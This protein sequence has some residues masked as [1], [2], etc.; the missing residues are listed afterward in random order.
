MTPAKLIAW[1]HSL[2]LTQAGAA[3]A[4]GLSLR[5]YARLEGGDSPISRVIELA[6]RQVAA[7]GAKH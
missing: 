4:L 5:Q 7:E 2:G 6:T 3:D 1:R